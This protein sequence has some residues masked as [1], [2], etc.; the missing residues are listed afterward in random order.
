MVGVKQRLRSS[1]LHQIVV[2]SSQSGQV[3]CSQFFGVLTGPKPLGHLPHTARPRAGRH[4]P[5]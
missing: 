2:E 4:S 1:Y 3:L 5:R